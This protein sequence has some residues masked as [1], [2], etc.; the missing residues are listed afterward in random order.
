[1]PQPSMDTASW[2]RRQKIKIM[3]KKGVLFYGKRKIYK[4]A[5]GEA[6]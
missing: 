5:G 1:M 2:M 3:Q 6:L 4:G